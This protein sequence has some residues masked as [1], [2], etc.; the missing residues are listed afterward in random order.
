MSMIFP[1]MDP[2]LEDPQI[3]PG[4]HSRLV[5][6]LA[7]QL[8]PKLRPRYVAAVEERVYIEGRRRQVVPDVSIR[9]PREP[10]HEG[11]V[12]VAVAVAEGDEPA[13]VQVDPLEVHESY[14]G[15]LDLRSGQEIVTVIEVVSPSNKARGPGRDSYLAKQS[16][17]LASTAHLVEID[18]LRAGEH[19]VA[20]PEWSARGI[21]Y[22]DYLVCVN[23]AYGV[24]SRYE[25][26]LRG[27]RERLPRVRIPLA[28]GDPDVAMDVQAAMARVCESGAYDQRIDYRTPCRPPLRPAD[29]EWVDQLVGKPAEGPGRPGQVP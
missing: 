20:V 7:D 25:L 26:Y 16:E 10:E 12:A 11:G 5:V 13:L 1:G 3:W 24:R 9:R 22:Y 17:V 21:G 15:I 14:L 23:R 2:Y 29:Q 8:Q 18:L 27:V 4:V 19:V 28:D 6:Y